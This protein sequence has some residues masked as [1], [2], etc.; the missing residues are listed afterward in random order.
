MNLEGLNKLSTQDCIDW[1]EQTC[2][3]KRWCT[4]MVKSRPFTSLGD[5]IQKAQ[6]HWS[7]MQEPDYLEAFEAHPMI[8]DL[9]SLRAKYANTATL[10]QHE[11]SGTHDASEQVLLQLQ[12]A[13]K[14]YLEQNGFIFIIC[15]TGLS[16]QTMLDA[17]NQRLC[18]SRQ[19]EIDIAAEQQLKI[20]MLR[21]NKGI[22]TSQQ[23]KVI[24]Q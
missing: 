12:Q 18:N 5:I 3:S 7:N 16:A 19:H 6:T 9:E 20:T 4:K 24:H 1:L 21:I 2:A 8:G 17:L 13:N 15:A 22:S 11:Q 14:T 23:E 10:A